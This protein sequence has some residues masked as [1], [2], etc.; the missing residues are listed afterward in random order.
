MCLHSLNIHVIILL[1]VE[2]LSEDEDD[3]IHSGHV[4]MSPNHTANPQG[5]EP[6]PGGPFSALTSS[7]WPE[8]ILTKLSNQVCYLELENI[9]KFFLSPPDL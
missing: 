5:F 9:R 4:G 8:D 2:T 7:M 1:T 3:V 6:T